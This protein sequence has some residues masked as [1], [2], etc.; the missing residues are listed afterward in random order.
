[1]KQK[2][3]KPSAKKA[4]KVY[5]ELEGGSLLCPVLVLDI[6][7]TLQKS[8][9]GNEFVSGVDDIELLPNVLEVVSAYRE[10]G[11]VIVLATNQGGV[12]YGHKT[13]QDVTDEVH[14]LAGLFPSGVVFAGFAALSMEGGNVP[15]Y[16]YRSLLRKPNYG[17]LVQA[18]IGM[19]DR[20]LIADWDNSIFVG[21]RDSDQQCA[22][23]AG[24]KFVHAKDFFNWK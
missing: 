4:A 3:K 14:H 7:G 12:A 9:S 21:D 22:Q 16:S 5:K 2:I 13:V 19:Q 11:Y 18:E 6:D 20:G 8:K 17:M 15:A 24:V 10:K 23:A 1:M